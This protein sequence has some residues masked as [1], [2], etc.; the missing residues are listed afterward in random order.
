MLA[1][2]RSP[3]SVKLALFFDVSRDLL[4]DPAKVSIMDGA[5][6]SESSSNDGHA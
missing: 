5:Y 2:R 3:A 1:V 4:D 6:S